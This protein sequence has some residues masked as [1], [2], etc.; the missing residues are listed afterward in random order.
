MRMVSYFGP[1]AV[2]VALSLIATALLGIWSGG[3][4]NHLTLG[5]FAAVLTV[6]VHSLMI[7]FMIITGRVLRAAMQSRPLGDTYLAELNEFF[8]K[9]PGYPAALL[10]A[11]AIVATGVLG[12]GQ[13][14]FGL[15][16]S[17]H[18]LVGLTAVVVNLWTLVIE[19][20]TLRD[21]QLLLDRTAAELDRIDREQPE[22]RELDPGEPMRFSPTGRWVLAGFVSWAPLAYWTLVVWKGSFDRISPVFL[23]VTILGSLGC[24]VS[25]WL[26][27]GLDQAGQPAN[28]ES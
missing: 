8:A 14:G 7:L 13:R 1:M 17:V 28:S 6:G 23:A 3:S 27:R 12:Y 5:L 18:M 24:F 15:P 26:T 2:L 9:K 16:R 21:N 19:F 20:K 11:L 25:A 22:E 4:S 10:A